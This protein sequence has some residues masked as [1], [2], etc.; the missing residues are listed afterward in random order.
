MEAKVKHLL[1][2]Y[3]SGNASAEEVKLLE[4][5]IEQ[6]EVQISDL[7]PLQAVGKS[8]GELEEPTP[9]G[10]MTANFYKQLSEV[11]SRKSSR[12]NVLVW[13]Q[14]LWAQQPGYQ[15]AYTLVI[16]AVGLT[17]GYLL[18]PSGAEGKTEIQELSAEVTEM[19]EMMMLSLLE[20]ESTSDRLKAV[21]LT[22][23]LPDVSGKVT[24]ALFKTLNTDPNVNVRLA[25]IEALYPYASHPEVRKGLV[26]SI[27]K[28]DSPL[29]QMALA[30][31]MVALQEKSS[32]KELERLLDKEETPSEVKDKIQ[33]SIKVLI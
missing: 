11:K 24:S 21:N 18:R 22:S 23:E 4:S 27:S 1:E 31:L 32:I 30:E 8:F 2:K 17:A 28:Q 10:E 19:K 3:N 33:E 9:S 12:H 6:G 16:L 14:S 29:V 15:W 26:K 25:T 7:T 20:K 5:Y 13:L